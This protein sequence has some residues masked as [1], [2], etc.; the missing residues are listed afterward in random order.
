MKGENINKRNKKNL[1][2]LYYNKKLHLSQ[3][4]KRWNASP[5]TISKLMKQFKISF[6]SNS[7]VRHLSEGNYSNL[8]SQSIDWISGELLGDGHIAQISSYSAQF[9]Y[10]SK[11][12]EYARYVKRTLKTFGIESSP[13]KSYIKHLSSIQ[14]YK[15][16]NVSS[17]CYPELLEIRKKWYPEGK[18]IVPRNI[19]LTPLTCRQWYIGDGS[20]CQKKR[21]SPG[22]ILSTYAFP[23]Q[24]VEFLIKQLKELNFQVTHSYKN[25][26]YMA[27]R[28]VRG[29]L[30]YIGTCPVRCYRYKWINQKKE[31]KLNG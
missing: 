6:R 27:P 5:N 17:H 15:Q 21:K 22:I 9:T 30:D 12:E 25:I 4:A 2:D 16:F 11:F 26:I 23:F 28:S 24:D 7:E 29:F 18:K 10:M 13:I 1:L 20:I 8:T 14:E 3:I 19:K 31:K